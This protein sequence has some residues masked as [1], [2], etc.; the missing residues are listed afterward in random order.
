M[1]NLVKIFK[2]SQ[3]DW[4]EKD[5][6]L[7]GNYLKQ[8]KQFNLNQQSEL[9]EQKIQQC[10]NEMEYQS[11]QKDEFIYHSYDYCDYIYILLDGT[12]S[13]LVSKSELEI[14]MEKGILM[15][16]QQLE[17]MLQRKQ[18]IGQSESDKADLYIQK[19]NDLNNQLEQDN[20]FN[21]S[22]RLKQIFAKS[23]LAYCQNES[24]Y[25]DSNFSNICLFKE[26]SQ[27]NSGNLIGEYTE[28]SLRNQ[29][30][31]TSSVCHFLKLKA[32]VYYKIYKKEIVQQQ[33]VKQFLKKLG[34]NQINQSEIE[35]I[36]FNIERIKVK[37]DQI[38][39]KQGD[40]AKQIIFLVQKGS[41]ELKF[42]L[43]KSILEE[44]PSSEIGKT[45][46]IDADNNKNIQN[47]NST[48][49]THHNGINLFK[50]NKSNIS[51]QEYK[52]FQVGEGEIFGCEELQNNFRNISVISKES[53]GVLY[54]IKIKQLK[55]LQDKRIIEKIYQYG[56][57]RMERI[58]RRI[59][60]LYSYEQKQQSPLKQINKYYSSCSSSPSNSHFLTNQ[61]LEQQQKSPMSNT[62]TD[63]TLLI[64][65]IT[66]N[67]E[68]ENDNFELG[69]NRMKS[70]QLLR[71]HRFQKQNKN[72]VTPLSTNMQTNYSS[73]R[74]L[75]MIDST[76][77]KSQNTFCISP[78]TQKNVDCSSNNGST[79]T[80][81]NSV[82]TS[83]N[84]L[85]II[86]NQQ[87]LK[88]QQFSDFVQL[89]QLQEKQDIS[90]YQSYQ[91]GVEIGSQLA[92]S[93]QPTS[94][95]H[96]KSIEKK[97]NQYKKQNSQL[98]N[99]MN[100]P[101]FFHKSKSFLQT[102][103]QIKIQRQKSQTKTTLFV[104]HSQNLID[105]KASQYDSLNT[106]NQASIIQ[107]NQIQ[108]SILYSKMLKSRLIH[109]LN[110]QSQ[111][112][113]KKQTDKENSNSQQK[114]IKQQ[115]LSLNR[116]KH[117]NVNNFSYLQLQELNKQKKQMQ[118]QKTPCSL[119]SLPEENSNNMSSN[120]IIQEAC[121]M[122]D[123]GCSFTANN[124]P[125]H[126]NSNSKG[127]VYYQFQY[128]QPLVKQ[129]AYSINAYKQI[130]ESRISLTNSPQK[131]IHTKTIYQSQS[132]S[133][134]LD[135]SS[136]NKN[137]LVSFQETDTK[138]KQTQSFNNFMADTT[139]N[140]NS[141]TQGLNSTNYNFF[142]P[143]ALTL[144]NTLKEQDKPLFNLE[145]K[146]NRNAYQPKY[147]TQNNFYIGK[148]FNNSS[149]NQ[150][151]AASKKINNLQ[152]Q[153]MQYLEI[154]PIKIRNTFRGNTSQEHN[155]Q[156]D[157][158]K[159]STDPGNRSKNKMKQITNQN[160]QQSQPQC[161]N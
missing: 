133:K 70:I 29:S 161:F 100:P 122:K 9:T 78:I 112:Q 131:N 105:S 3:S 83:K 124:S 34:L 125:K 91:E 14:E 123:L 65:Q 118:L 97:I 120:N 103:N 17:Q 22:R 76:L 26:Q 64:G 96:S 5:K 72:A 79:S 115:Q 106:N 87:Q 19:I 37:K 88:N 36:S 108:Q 135:I 56:Q 114:M 110:N 54:K 57:N 99:V 129:R 2:K 85:Y 143:Q 7:L 40:K 25:F 95:T 60:E 35:Q 52:L 149:I 23:S 21:L 77:L 43:N 44:S 117:K 73:R 148:N 156:K 49:Q 142:E 84:K 128:Q 32:S 20:R 155:T 132:N 62:Q 109:F 121:T 51:C 31:L 53:K 59:Q 6:T 46:E 11:Y 141:K 24:Y 63:S 15:Q 74:A 86:G 119:N 58:N 81:F 157:F 92:F 18:Q 154:S 153:Q 10:I 138:F 50:I 101:Q 151:N 30:I 12:A 111:M 127:I 66:E 126:K 39:F 90:N 68:D 159:T 145:F 69:S 61:L 48:T 116:L 71:S 45:L 89:H 113:K 160:I 42:Y 144:I 55:E 139:L 140:E 41:F 93:S 150:S 82:K 28:E 38:I 98:K 130:K 27:I 136:S 94:P 107:D 8:L 158:K 152:Q 137:N 16:I 33:K 146:Q 104:N 75:S 147:K 67:I 80:N 4:S 13:Q 134:Y 102:Q 1:S 47:Q